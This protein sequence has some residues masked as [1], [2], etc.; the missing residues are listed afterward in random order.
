MTVIFH[1]MLGAQSF[2]PT[3]NDYGGNRYDHHPVPR[4]PG[5]SARPRHG[6]PLDQRPDASRERRCHPRRALWQQNRISRP[7]TSWE[8]PALK[9]E[10]AIVDHQTTARWSS[11]FIKRLASNGPA[12][13]EAISELLLNLR[14]LYLSL[15]VVHI[16]FGILTLNHLGLIHHELTRE[17]RNRHDETESEKGGNLVAHKIELY[18]LFFCFYCSTRE[19][20]LHQICPLK[21]LWGTIS[22]KKKGLGIE[23]AKAFFGRNRTVTLRRRRNNS[24]NQHCRSTPADQE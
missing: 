2:L 24:A 20:T 22:A 17:K 23:D 16:C 3:R 6:S 12:K 7:R 5:R 21:K 13:P 11:F 18:F 15:H 4:H 8:C 10:S 9:D 14:L 1:D 19:N